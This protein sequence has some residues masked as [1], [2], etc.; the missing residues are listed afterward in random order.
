MDHSIK[1]KIHEINRCDKLPALQLQKIACQITDFRGEIGDLGVESRIF[2]KPCPSITG[3]SM[4]FSLALTCR[5]LHNGLWTRFRPSN[6]A[7]F[8]SRTLAGG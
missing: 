7:Q 5:A 3:G 2:R 4:P 8:D 6:I 1:A